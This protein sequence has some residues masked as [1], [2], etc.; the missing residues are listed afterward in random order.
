M[1]RYLFINSLPM[2]ENVPDFD[3]LNKSEP[4]DDMEWFDLEAEGQQFPTTTDI[5]SKG[6]RDFA[7]ALERLPPALRLKLFQDEF[8]TDSILGLDAALGIEESKDP[9]F[10]QFML[11]LSQDEA[12]QIQAAFRRTIFVVT[13][14]EE[15]MGY[16]HFYLIN[17]LATERI[18]SLHG[19]VFASSPQ[20]GTRQWKRWF[21]SI[22]FD[23]V[24]MGL[25]SGFPKES[26]KKYA[27]W[28]DLGYRYRHYYRKFEVIKNHP[29]SVSGAD[30]DALDI[31]ATD[32]EFLQ[33]Y[34]RTGG[35]IEGHKC[36]IF[37][38][39]D[40]R[41]MKSRAHWKTRMEN[42]FSSQLAGMVSPVLDN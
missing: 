15:I 41:Y 35:K 29:G 28:E 12:S 7:K 14:V 6:V 21:K 31:T 33:D 20:K 11:S 32:R 8:L 39:E 26:V 30:I 3:Q 18:I 4:D 5:A 17:R 37:S 19:D 27:D 40:N 25:L 24:K 2:T 16:L 36:A 9:K 38:Q 34:L 1:G 22:Q 42:L 10:P 13:D 23:S